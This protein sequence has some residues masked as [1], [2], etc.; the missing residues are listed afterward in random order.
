MQSKHHQCIVQF[1]LPP[2]DDIAIVG[3]GCRAP[4]ADN[5]QEFWR[6]LQNGE[7][8]VT[9]VPPDRWNTSAYYNEDPTA[10][11]KSYVMR[12]GFMSE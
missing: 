10:L 4:G 8:H 7:C 2:Q 9:D 1:V 12:G 3:V 11:G 5:I 6:V